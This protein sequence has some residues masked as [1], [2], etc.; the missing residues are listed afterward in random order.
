MPPYMVFAATIWL[1]DV[2]IFN[3]VYVMAAAPDATQRA[4][5]PFSRADMRFSNTSC[6]GLD[7]RPYMFPSSFSSNLAEALAQSLNTYDVVWYIGT[8][9]A[10]VAGSGDSCPTCSCIVS[11]RY[12]FFAIY[13]FDVWRL[14][15]ISLAKLVV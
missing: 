2:A 8:A 12:L 1:P 11:N 4:D 3:I 7:R 5:F 6:V 15:L 10:S 14:C 13:I 9:L